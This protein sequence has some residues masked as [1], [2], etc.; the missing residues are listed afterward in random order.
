MKEIHATVMALTDSECRA[1][2][3][4]AVDSSPTAASIVGEVAEVIDHA[5]TMEET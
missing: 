3:L 1:A 5:R 2:L 4:I